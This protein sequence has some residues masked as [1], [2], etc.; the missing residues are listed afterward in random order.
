M[1]FKII[2]I[3]PLDNCADHIR[4]NLARGEFYFFDNT[5]RPS[6]DLTGIEKKE[7]QSSLPSNFFSLQSKNPNTSLESINIHAVVGK[8]GSGKSSLI[9]LMIRVLNNFFKAQKYIKLTDRLRYSKGV[10]AELY[11]S[12]G[13]H[14]YKIR[15]D[16]SEGDINDIGIKGEIATITPEPDKISQELFFTMYVNYS[17]YGLDSGDFWKE[18]VHENKDEETDDESWLDKVFHKNDGYQ[19]QLVIHPWRDN[20][21]IDIRNEKELMR[22]RLISQIILDGSFIE[23]TEGLNV[24]SF[25]LKFSEV[26]FLTEYFNKIFDITGNDGYIEEKYP[27]KYILEYLNEFLSDINKRNIDLFEIIQKLINEGI[28]KN[29]ADVRYNKGEYFSDYVFLEKF[30]FLSDSQIEEIIYL[31]MCFEVIEA[32]VGNLEDFEG[33]TFL[34]QLFFYAIVKLRKTLRY[35]RYAFIN[36]ESYLFQVFKKGP[37]E[38]SK[39]NI[40]DIIKDDSHISIKLR[41]A[42]EIL[43]LAKDTPNSALIQFY[44][45]HAQNRK[46]KVEGI[47]AL[48][49]L[50]NQAVKERGIE[51]IYFVPPPVFNI[52]I[53]LSKKNK[54][55]NGIELDGNDISW[56]S[57]SS[58][59]FQKIGIISS[60]VYHL[61][62]LDSVRSHKGA[63][64]N[65]YNY[66]NVNIMLDEIELYFHPEYQR[67]FIYDLLLKL[68][69]TIFK[70]IKNINITFITHSPFI[71]SDIP[72]QNILKLKEGKVETDNVLN[73]FAANIHDLLRDD[74]FLKGGSMG[75]FASKKIDGL[76]RYLYLKSKIL[77]LENDVEIDFYSK[78]IKEELK[79]LLIE[80]KREIQELESDNNNKHS[81]HIIS[82][83]GEPILKSKLQELYTKI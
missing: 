22:Q 78:S 55:I 51:P 68:E 16:T 60:L 49:E 50:I 36:A 37:L 6:I 43:K 27:K 58:G 69:K 23:F 20:G 5:Y 48:R 26:D 57:I 3:R 40:S 67:T 83:I 21:Q 10:A 41:Q 74:F 42:I 7:E 44:H 76:V 12:I 73:S 19:T 54:E 56:K 35:P 30:K 8:N 11:F 1:S 13:E 14:V 4:K 47:S 18:T 64:E 82:L 38:I 53:L 2:A 33:T 81:K 79:K 17:L 32:E 61:N 46:Q 29:F 66:E 77:E 62:N 63:Q 24:R 28:A 70:Q 9:E 25:V 65:F 75:E 34:R 52:D 15:V 72:S 39:K 31:F 80:C 45:D 71:L 59:E